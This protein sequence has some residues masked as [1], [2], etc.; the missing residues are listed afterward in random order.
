MNKIVNVLARIFMIV[1]GLTFLFS[2]FVKAVDP[3][4]GAIK[5]EDYFNA[6]HLGFLGFLSLPLSVVL[7][8]IE[9]LIGAHLVMAIRV[10][11]TSWLALLFMSFFTLLTLYLAIANPVTDCGC[12]GDAVKLTNWETFFKNL[13]LLPM[14]V[15]VF[16][17]RNDI[18]S[19]LGKYRQLFLSVVY[20]VAILCVSWFGYNHFPLFD[21]RPYKIGVNIQSAM[22]IPPGAQ[23][24]VYK[25]RFIL[26]KNGERK[27]FDEFNYPYNDSTWVFI[28]QKS[29]LVEEGYQ[30]PVHN[31]SLRTLTGEDVTDQILNSDVPVFLMIAPHL[32]Q[33]NVDNIK[34]LS[35]LHVLALEK[36]F[37]FYCLTSS[38]S[39]EI[40]DFDM[41]LNVGLD[42][43]LVDETE[44]KTIT[45]ANPGLILLDRGTILG[46]WNANDIED[47]R[48][49]E[50]PI[51]A[52]VSMMRDRND[53]VMAFAC[54]FL[55]IAGTSIVFINRK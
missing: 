33:T 43:L 24:P 23:Q 9:F 42:Y 15:F 3:V 22:S 26:E 49:F 5:F 30:P 18:K 31:F 20:A 32:S 45:R 6:F 52:T 16:W 53:K 48:V 51:S 34:V 55:I 8:A 39:E 7:A 35:D 21:F 36:G 50:E 4:G 54:I 19:Q 25:T 12:F 47:S 40:R 38:L 2:G 14:A 27:E 13:I 44:L 41:H 28:D 10:K 46:K 17:Y 1:V 11:L 29:T 37:K